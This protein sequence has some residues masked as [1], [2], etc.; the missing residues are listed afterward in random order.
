MG[1]AK[2]SVRLETE[3]AGQSPPIFL[4]TYQ[5]HLGL[6]FALGLRVREDATNLFKAGHELLFGLRDNVTAVFS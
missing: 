2:A 5:K 4:C 3:M 1:K 6:R